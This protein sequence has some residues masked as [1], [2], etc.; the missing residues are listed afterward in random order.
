MVTHFVRSDA[1]L[2]RAITDSLNSH[3]AASLGELFPNS[4]TSSVSFAADYAAV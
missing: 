2:L 4:S 1:S 3:L